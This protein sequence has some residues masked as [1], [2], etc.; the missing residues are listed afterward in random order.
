MN[1]DQYD[2]QLQ[3]N[4]VS[5]QQSHGMDA[6]VRDISRAAQ[7]ITTSST[8]QARH[9]QSLA[10]S[11]QMTQ[12]QISS[13]TNQNQV[14]VNQMRMDG[15]RQS[16]AMSTPPPMPMPMSPSPMAG[17][18]HHDPG[19]FQSMVMPMASSFAN[20]RFERIGGATELLGH[21]LQ[22]GYIGTQHTNVGLG[23]E[24]GRASCREGGE[25]VEGCG[26]V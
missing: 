11:V 3:D 16:T 26:L 14:L 12:M 4:F 2:N 8:S 13:L 7:N 10:Q 18:Y 5:S 23:L 9:S 22:S 1:F 20:Q 19:V 21:G 6:A 17:A 25:S 15:I 24:I